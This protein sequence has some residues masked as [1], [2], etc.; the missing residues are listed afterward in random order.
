MRA[1]APTYSVRAV[2]IHPRPGLRAAQD[3]RRW[4]ARRSRS[5][6]RTSEPPQQGADAR[7]VRT[8]RFTISLKHP[9]SSA[10]HK[11]PADYPI[12]YAA[13]GGQADTSH[14]T[15]RARAVYFVHTRAHL[16]VGIGELTRR[17]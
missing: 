12:F 4:R 8:P 16:V 2:R 11:L 1:R 9:K 10:I 6:K 3:H 13:V 17:P 14:I 15:D 5:A 7:S